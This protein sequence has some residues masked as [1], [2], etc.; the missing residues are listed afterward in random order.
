MKVV[1]QNGMYW[2][3]HWQTNGMTIPSHSP[4]C[5][6]MGCWDVLVVL[7]ALDPSEG[8]GAQDIEPGQEGVVQLSC[9][10]AVQYD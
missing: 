7:Q 5:Y 3:S 2:M 10:Y 8:F 1:V 6:E 4:H 9:F